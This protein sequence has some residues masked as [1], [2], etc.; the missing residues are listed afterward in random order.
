MVMQRA[1]FPQPE[2]TLLLADAA[3]IKVLPPSS[4]QLD[5]SDNGP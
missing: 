1:A 4:S 5:P 2:L 3:A